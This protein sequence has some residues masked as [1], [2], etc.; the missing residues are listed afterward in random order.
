MDERIV[1]LETLVAMQ[2]ET[3]I[4]M[5]RETYRQQQELQ[6]MALRLELLETKM[7][8]LKEAPEIGGNEKPPHY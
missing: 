7:Q 3:I 6:R 1:R 2:D 5:S 8:E 4:G